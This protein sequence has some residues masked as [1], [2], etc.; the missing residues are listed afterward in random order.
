M[1]KI[2]IELIVKKIITLFV[3][4]DYEA[5]YNLDRAKDCS[6]ESFKEL[7]EDYGGTLTMPP[8]EALKEVEIY[9]IENDDLTIDFA[10]DFDFWVNGKRSD[11]TLQAII[12]NSGDPT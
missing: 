7:I 1:S 12:F 6:P 5:I 2:K 9:K 10:I 8:D 3:N 4:R 11:L